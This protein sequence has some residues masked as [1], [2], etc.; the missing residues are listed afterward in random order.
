MRYINVAII[1]LL[2]LGLAGC[3]PKQPLPTDD[4]R[5]LARQQVPCIVVLPVETK[6][7]SDPNVTYETAAEL[8]K[9]AVFMDTVLREQMVGQP[10]VRVV[11]TRQFTSLIPSES[12]D[13]LTLLK[14]IGAELNCNAILQTTLIRFRQRV[15]SSYAAE[16]PAAATF[17][18][19]LFDTR[20]GRVLWSS[21]F[22]ETQQSVMANI[23]TLGSGQ[24]RG[25]SWLTVEE[26]VERGIEEQLK[27][28][29]YL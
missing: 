24:S 21:R 20:D 5:Q 7:N 1:L 28:C 27:K 12:V 3:G 19:R 10:N 25:L 29:P 15:G 22:Q 16:V 13:Q 14:S 17:S 23:M 6:V 8:E 11:S 18:F 26:L 2:T 4:Q 9:G